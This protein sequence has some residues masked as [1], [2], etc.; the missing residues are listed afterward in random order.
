MKKFQDSG[1]IN[2]YLDFFKTSPN[3]PISQMMNSV[4]EQNK[5]KYSDYTQGQVDEFRRQVS[6]GTMS[7]I[8]DKDGKAYFIRTE[9]PIEADN[10]LSGFTPVGDAMEM[11]QI[12]DDI[13]S[14][15]YRTAALATVL[16]L[17]PGN[18]RKLLTT[19]IPVKSDKFIDFFSKAI[20]K[21]VKRV[22]VTKNDFGGV[23][24]NGFRYLD[25]S[26]KEIA[27]IAGSKHGNRVFVESSFM[28]PEFRSRGIGKQMYFDFNDQIFD[29]YGTTI[30]SNS[31]QHMMTIELPGSN[32]RISPSGK[33]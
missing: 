28:D 6:N 30:G 26:G 15:N 33:L 21:P 9:A 3:S 8:I 17:L 10:V 4:T 31:G 19:L 32:V 7:E 12:G 14:G 11:I 2:P 25:E 24:S 23:Y 20:G 27:H 18:A 1:K 16:T 22:P 29:K 5:H 13:K